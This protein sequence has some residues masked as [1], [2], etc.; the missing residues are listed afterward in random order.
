[1]ASDAR[2]AVDAINAQ[3]GINGH[4]L[5][6]KTCDEKANV[7]AATQCARDFVSAGVVATTGDVSVNAASYNPILQRAGIVRIGPGVTGSTE[8]TAPNN[9]P[10]TGGPITYLAG[11][12]RAAARAG[13][14]SV[15]FLMVE[16]SESSAFEGLLKPTMQAVS[17]VDKGMVQVPSNAP[18][19]SPYVT[20][21]K[22][23]GVDAVIA[24][25]NPQA[26]QQFLQVSEQLGAT[27]RV[28]TGAAAFDDAALK[29][30][31]S[32]TDGLLVTDSLPPA[33]ATQFTTIQQF[34]DELAARKAAGDSKTSPLYLETWLAVHAFATVAD[35]I[36]GEITRHSLNQALASAKDLNIGDI[37]PPWTPSATGS[38]LPRVTN[39][40]GY[41]DQIKD[42]KIE[43]ADPKRQLFMGTA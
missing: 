3:G 1:V 5:L 6:L 41:F 17:V 36:P 8:Y 32:L 4:Q 40:D 12:I 29:A 9:Y 24:I 21:I 19:L 27:Y 43:L 11:A 34:N 33:T 16:S 10:I 35:T 26:L 20:R 37:T 13:A 15:A 23:S 25:V 7:N 14:K 18:D 31:G 30:L 2:A 39:G 28:A 22:D 38:V 42:G